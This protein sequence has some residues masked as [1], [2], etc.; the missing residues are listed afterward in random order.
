MS[1]EAR[2]LIA[3]ELNPA[4][5][6]VVSASAW[7]VVSEPIL[8]ML[9]IVVAVR[10]GTCVVVIAGDL[11]RRQIAGVHGRRERVDLR[12]GQFGDERRAQCPGDWSC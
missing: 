4:I 9:L 6:V 11:R 1:V 8:L 10:P 2:A 3:V 7:V 12:R 5:W